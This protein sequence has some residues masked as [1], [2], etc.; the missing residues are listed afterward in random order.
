MSKRQALPMDLR[1]K[2]YDRYDELA[3]QKEQ[4]KRNLVEKEHQIKQLES[5]GKS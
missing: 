1:D 3:S 5:D 2:Q 4:A